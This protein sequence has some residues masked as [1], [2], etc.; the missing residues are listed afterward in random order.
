ML[1]KEVNDCPE[2]IKRMM[3][4]LLRMRVRPYY[5]LQCDAIR[6]SSHFRTPISTGIEIIKSLRGH[7]T[8]YAVPHFIVDLKTD[9]T[10]H[11]KLSNCILLVNLPRTRKLA[12]R[13]I[14][15]FLLI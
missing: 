8:G 4:G 11:Y 3:H 14:V 9:V 7:T 2:V 12:K 1:L 15:A 13:I 10:V 5:L 6:G